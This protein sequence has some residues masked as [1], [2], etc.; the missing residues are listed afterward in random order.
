MTISEVDLKKEH[1]PLLTE[2][3]EKWTHLGAKL[4]KQGKNV[5]YFSLPY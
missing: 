4:S 1:E 5:G 2:E 3:T